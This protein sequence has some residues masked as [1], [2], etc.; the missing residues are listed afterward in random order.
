MLFRSNHQPSTINH[1]PS[2]INHQSSTINHQPSII[3][4]QSS[5]NIHQKTN[6]RKMTSLEEED[7]QGLWI[8]GY[9]SLVWRPSF[10]FA[11]RF[12]LVSVSVSVSALHF[13]TP[14]NA[15]HKT[16]KEGGLHQRL[17][18]EVLAGKHRPQRRSSASHRQIMS[19]SCL[20]SRR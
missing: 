3:N 2:T 6:E 13:T 20:V 15:L 16:Q 14:D 4:H 17:G 5:T 19:C 12:V 8:F 9:G 11:E 10:D 1:Q 18:Q 7:A